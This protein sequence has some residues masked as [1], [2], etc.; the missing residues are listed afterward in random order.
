MAAET[1]TVTKSETLISYRVNL[2][3]GAAMCQVRE[4]WKDAD[5]NVLKSEVVDKP[6]S[7]A[8]ATTEAVK[9]GRTT[10]EEDDLCK[11]L[12]VGVVKLPAE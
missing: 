8:A 1:K 5:G 4:E 10:W 12:G 11:V 6:A 7:E 9:A 3:A 2:N